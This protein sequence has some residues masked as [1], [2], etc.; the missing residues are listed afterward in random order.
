MQ[1]SRYLSQ[2]LLGLLSRYNPNIWREQENPQRREELLR[3]FEGDIGAVLYGIPADAADIIFEK[4]EDAA[5]IATAPATA[6]TSIPVVEAVGALIERLALGPTLERRY[7][8][9][10]NRSHPNLSIG[11]KAWQYI[12]EIPGLDSILS[13]IPEK[14]LAAVGVLIHDI[15]RVAGDAKRAGRDYVKG[16]YRRDIGVEGYRDERYQHPVRPLMPSYA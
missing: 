5:E 13:I 11:L 8:E 7:H 2:K 16:M 6:G 1:I 15:Y 14:S 12:T 9:S 4:A 3:R 10:M